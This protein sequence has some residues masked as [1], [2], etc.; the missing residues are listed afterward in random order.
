MAFAQA[1]AEH[2]NT[3]TEALYE[4]DVLWKNQIRLIVE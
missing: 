2:D 1:I 3:G 4:L